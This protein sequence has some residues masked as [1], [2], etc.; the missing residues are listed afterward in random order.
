MNIFSFFA[1]S[2]EVPPIKAERILH[3]GPI[4]IHNS[5]LLGWLVFGLVLI[6][7]IWIAHRIS[8]R[9]SKN[10]FVS[11]IEAI[12]EYVVNLMDGIM[13][14]RAKAIKFA[15]L[16]LTLFFVILINNWFGL[17]PG[18][19]HSLLANT[20]AGHVPFLRSFSSDLNDTLSLAIVTMVLVQIYSIRELGGLGYFKHF[21]TDKPYNPIYIFV[22][23]IEVLG[24]FTKIMSLSLRLFGNIFAGEVLLF[25]ITSISGWLA[26]VISLPFVFL[27]AFGGFIQAFVFAMLAI[28]YLTISTTGHSS[29]DEELPVQQSNQSFDKTKMAQAND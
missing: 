21:F 6:G 19:G 2:L 18:V 20:P 25:V 13:N 29:H 14:D 7:M 9:P 10:R 15:P 16:I 8:I 28:V 24:E 4:G 17:L 5:T 1:E 12:C 23:L 3:L 11:A 26:P 27:E 22:G